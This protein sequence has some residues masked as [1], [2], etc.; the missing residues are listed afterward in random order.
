MAEPVPR[1]KHSTQTVV[2][3]QLQLESW[4]FVRPYE[5]PGYS[6]ADRTTLARQARLAYRRLKIPET[7][8]IWDYA[9]RHESDVAPSGST[10]PVVAPPAAKS[11]AGRLIKKPSKPKG[12]TSE[13]SKRKALDVPIIAKD[14]SSRAPRDVKGKDRDL[15]DSM[16]T[17]RAGAA[18]TTTTTTVTS[19]VAKSAA[20]KLPGSGYKASTSTPPPA[21]DA[22][23]NVAPPTKKTGVSVNVRTVTKPVASPSLPPKPN[24]P[25]PSPSHNHDRKPSASNGTTLPSVR[26]KKQRESEPSSTSRKAEPARQKERDPERQL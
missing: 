18:G 9:R 11:Q 6:T 17:N 25:M 7:D 16:S 22:P 10:P 12:K 15:G 3:Y 23:S 8:P 13:G 26:E 5:W 14:E 24:F 2:Q 4:R 1:P 19:T 20:R 21:Q